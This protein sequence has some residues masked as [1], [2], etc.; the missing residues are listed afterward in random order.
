[1][2]FEAAGG[3][4]DIPITS[5]DEYVSEE[6]NPENVKQVAALEIFV[7]SPLLANWHVL[8]GHARVGIGIHGNT[9]ATRAFIPHID[10]ALV[11]IGADPPLA[12]EE[13]VLVE[14]VAQHVRDLIITV[15]KA[16]RTTDAERAEAVAFARRQI[17]KRLPRTFCRT[18]V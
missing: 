3:W 18:F 8:R 17:E 16:D 9:A 14:A 15:N 1:M 10:A 2:R 11:V 6:K 7:P 5:V 4:I 13:L 12:G